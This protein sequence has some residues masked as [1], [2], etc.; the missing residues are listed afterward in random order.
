[1]IKNIFILISIAYC[2][3]STAQNSTSSP[4]SIFALGAQNNASFGGFNALGNTGVANTDATQINNINPANLANIFENSMLYEIGTNAVYNTIETNSLSQ[5]TLDFNFSHIA[6][7][8]PIK[9]NWGM[10]VGLLPYSKVGYTIDI[11]QQAEGDSF[12]YNTTITGSGGLNKMYWSTGFSLLK[13]LS[14]GLE[15]SFLFGSIQQETVVFTSPGVNI[16]ESSYYNGLTLKT[17]VQYTL[18]FSK[19]SKT[20]LGASFEFPTSLNGTQT[21]TTYKTINQSQYSE[22]TEEELDIDNFELPSTLT[23]GFNT[24]INKN[25]STSFDFKKLWWNGSNQ[26][27]DSN[28]FSDQTI[29]GFGL[30]YSPKKKEYGITNHLKYRFGLNYNTGYLTISNQKI[31]SYQASVGLGIPFSN[32]SLSK[33]NISYSYG[34]EGT[35]SNN[36]IQENY[37]KLSVNLSLVGNWF[38]KRL[39]H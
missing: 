11:E 7:A 8:F 36:L 5:N 3:Q 24:A 14:F 10:G 2:F 31:D 35:L 4:Y 33:L 29:Y 20:T 15:T 1:M 28:S 13:N 18:P 32:G 9:K 30:E 6:I 38:K 23:L 37:H 17:G 27:N 16:N 22:T 39:I 19:K 21:R 26:G 12:T 34:K 25:I